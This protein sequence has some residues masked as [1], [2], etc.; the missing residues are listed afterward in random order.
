MADLS[1]YTQGN[2]DG[3]CTM[4]QLEN[5][6]GVVTETELYQ[7]RAAAAYAKAIGAVIE[8]D[9]DEAKSQLELFV[10]YVGILRELQKVTSDV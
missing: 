4:Q 2:Q 10:G 9:W 6:I 7:W 8:E 1:K 5:L 3:T